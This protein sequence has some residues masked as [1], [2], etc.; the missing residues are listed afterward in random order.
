MKKN[1][2]L[3]EIDKYNFEQKDGRIIKTS[4]WNGVYTYPMLKTNNIGKSKLAFD[5]HNLQNNDEILLLIQN[6]L[7]E[8]DSFIITERFFSL[9]E[10]NW[11]SKNNLSKI[12]WNDITFIRIVN[13][14][15]IV[16]LKNGTESAFDVERMFPK[17]KD[18]SQNLVSLMQKILE[19]SRGQR[20]T[21]IGT[22]KTIT[23]K[24]KNFL[25]G[26][27]GFGLLLLLAGS[28]WLFSQADEKRDPSTFVN[29][30][31]Q[32]P[33]VVLPK[34]DTIWSSENKKDFTKLVTF[35]LINVFHEPYQVT[36]EA[37]KLLGMVNMGGDRII[38]PVEI[39]E[40]TKY[41]IY[42]LTLSNARAESGEGN[43][44]NDVSYSV[45]KLSLAGKAVKE[46]VEVES[47]LTR[48]LLNTITAPT[49]EEPFTNAYFIDSQQQATNFQDSKEF[50]YDINNSIKNT[51]SRNG[52]IKFNKNQ[53]VYL[54]LENEGYTDN[55]YVGLEVVAL[56]ENTKYYKLVEKK[57]L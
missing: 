17:N 26:G 3:R 31:P 49:K 10:S 20:Q 43:L 48:E 47:S 23:K 1:T 29:S 11:F 28:F 36:M 33:A 18:K 24:N 35:K 25:F 56:I 5:A 13:H 34:Y 16:S 6:G 30:E 8:K 15:I 55:I 12:L 52:L 7:T 9:A 19:I 50:K 42:R 53:F 40:N 32:K 14:S 44:V 39:P 57:I 37:H 38:I 27:I 21:L 46:N 41:W 54:G 22:D 45:K 2:I 4:I 51:H